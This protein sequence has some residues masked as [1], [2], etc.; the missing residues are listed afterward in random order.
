MDSIRK[1]E[2]QRKNITRRKSRNLLENLWNQLCD[3][4]R[5]RLR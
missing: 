4:L 3:Q 2:F 1:E 5:I